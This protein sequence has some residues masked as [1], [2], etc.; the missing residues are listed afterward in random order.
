MSRSLDATDWRIL[1]ELQADGRLS[2]NQ[3]G[4]R[5]NLSPPAV[6]ERVRRLE[7]AGVI[8]G[9]R[10]DVSPDAVG[11]PLTAFLQL[12]C[13]TGHC[14][15]RTTAAADFPEVVEV[16]KLS[17]SF[18]TMLKVRATSLA[19]LESLIERIGAHR[20][21][22]SHVVLSTQYERRQVEPPPEDVPPVSG[23]GG[24][25]GPSG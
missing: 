8:T 1:A 3:L 24:W 10:A 25:P 17:G 2:Y 23:S 19:H 11:Q 12:R 7:E 16:H 21:M 22:N 13:E 9:Y 6:A 4:R 15:L 5:V 18:C 14:L 20:N